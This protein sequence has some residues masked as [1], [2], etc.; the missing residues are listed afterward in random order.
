MIRAMT[1]KTVII[2][3]LVGLVLSL[4]V[5]I[6][7]ARNWHRF[8]TAGAGTIDY[9][10]SV[11]QQRVTQTSAGLLYGFGSGLFRAGGQVDVKFSGGSASPRGGPLAEFTLL[12]DSRLQPFA[13]GGYSRSEDGGH[14][15]AGGGFEVKLR[16]RLAIRAFAQ[17]VIRR[18]SVVSPFGSMHR[19]IHEP[20]F[21]VGLA[22]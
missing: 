2:G 13:N 18:S 11:P 15:I 22:W 10:P 7:T 6:G 19:T 8:V 17:D 20:S 3:G 4:C 9:G 16:E 5:P 21:Q 12:T 14:W 1:R